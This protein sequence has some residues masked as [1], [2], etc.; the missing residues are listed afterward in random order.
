M[1]LFTYL[2]FVSLLLAL[3]SSCE[4]DEAPKTKT[5]LDYSGFVKEGL[6]AYYPMNDNAN[7]YGGN[8]HHGILHGA[9]P[10]VDRF[11][12]KKGAY[13]FDGEDDFIEILNSAQF[14]G[15]SGTI[16]FWARIPP[17]ESGEQKVI[18]S[19]AGTSDGGILI[20]QN[21]NEIATIIK[22]SDPTEWT[23][24]I[25][26]TESEYFFAAVTFTEYSLTTYYNGEFRENASYTP[27]KLFNDN[28]QT[29]YIGK[30][31]IDP[32]VIYYYQSNEGEV[33]NF[34]G[35]LDDVLIYDRELT[36]DEIEQ[37]SNW[38]KN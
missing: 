30:T 7:D 21:E 15:N 9:V 8:D 35:E 26:F 23:L 22:L 28:E 3:T 37:L 36:D 38:K 25:Y 27:E 14:N 18:F 17:S 29:L 2:A 32:D 16:C 10:S 4:K 11:G 12:G 24:R 33:K 31:I 34:K 5:Y 20:N 13:S 1:K 19:K 6:V